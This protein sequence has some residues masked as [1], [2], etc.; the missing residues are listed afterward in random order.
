MRKIKAGRDVIGQI[1]HLPLPLPT[2]LF[3]LPSPPARLVGRTADLQALLNELAPQGSPGSEDGRD[4]DAREGGVDSFGVVV[5]ALA[6][7]GGV[8][9]TALALAAGAIAHHEQWFCA[10]LYVDL[11]GHTPGADPLPAEVALDV[12]LRQAGADPQDIPP[13]P[14]ERAAF[15]R[16]VL[17]GLSEADERHRPVLVVADNARSTAQVRPLLPGP[18]RHRLV[19]TTRGGLHSLTGTHRLDLDVLAPQD[20]LALLAFALK[21]GDPRDTRAGDEAGLGRLAGVCGHLPLALEIAAAQLA[22]KPRLPPGRLAERLET[23]SRVDKLTDRGPDAE[24]TRVLRAVFDTSLDQ[25]PPQE[26]RVFLLVACAPGPTTSTAAAAALTGLDVG[27][28]EE[29]LEELQAVHLLTQPAA[30]RWGAHDLLVDYARTHPCPPEDRR[31]ALDRL[32]DFYTD[33][34]GAA[35]GHVRALP[36]DPVSDLFADR[37]AA[38]AWL[39][40][41][42]PTLVAAAL[43]APGLGHSRAAIDLPSYLAEYLAHRRRFEELEQVARSALAAARAHGDQEGEAMAWNNLGLALRQVRRFEE[44]VDAHTR[45]RDLYRQVGDAHGEAIAWNNLGGELRQVRQLKEAI[46]AHTRVRDLYRQV[47]NTHGEATAWNDLGLVLA[48][49][50]RFGEA[51]DAHTLARDLFQQVGD[52]HGE[53]LTWNNLG[54]ALAEVRRFEEAIEAH[55]RAR[56]LYQE[57]QDSHG[58]ALAWGNLGNALRQVRRFKVAIDILIHTC[59]LFRQLGDA[60]GEAIAQ[61]NLGLALAEV[62]R[63]EEAIDAYYRSGDLFQQVG[64]AYREMT[65][66]NNLGKVLL[67]VHQFDEAA[68]AYICVRELLYQL[69]DPCGEAEGPFE[70]LGD[71]HSATAAWDLSSSIFQDSDS[72]EST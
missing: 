18:G 68:D 5:S 15:Y 66:R 45:A 36:A 59:S 65:A 63:F 19:A 40:A 69:G 34:T 1:V 22:R 54:L 61:N 71:D 56:A 20:S 26:A 14:A 16:S 33:V 30:G 67:Q 9:K 35:A 41:E 21:A 72:K 29:A 37:R 6:G 58:E 53:A 2:A 50:R 3:S 57:V 4:A 7:M 47:G 51:I 62:R 8:G 55:T 38:L 52:V 31:R 27:E 70:V 44:A 13:Q 42:R 49:V 60:H 46:D 10:E 64:D 11:R 17:A 48:E 28:A 39:D 25:L 32:L 24:R 43:A 23:A 12:L